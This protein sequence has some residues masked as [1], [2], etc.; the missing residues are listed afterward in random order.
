[1]RAHPVQHGHVVSD[2]GRLSNDE[3]RGM[4]QHD[5]APNVRRGM[6][7]AVEDL[8]VCGG[9]QVWGVK[10]RMPV[11][12]SSTMPRPMCAAGWMSQSKTCKC[13][14]VWGGRGMGFGVLACR[15]LVIVSELWV[16]STLWSPLTLR[17]P[18]T[19][20]ILYS[21]IGSRALLNL[22]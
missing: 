3:P 21:Q 1:M 20:G 8:C 13:M 6:D 17:A 4:V 2:D 10:C 12:W 16:P 15:H 5:A 7:V 18:S 9:V 22:C 19:F 11:A 14:C